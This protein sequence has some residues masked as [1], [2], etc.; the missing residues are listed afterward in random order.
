MQFT[1]NVEPWWWFK[2]CNATV[3]P[4]GGGFADP[5]GV[6]IGMW[7]SRVLDWYTKGVR[8]YT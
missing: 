1:G 6:T 4:C 7:H 2:G 3:C 5:S 8:A